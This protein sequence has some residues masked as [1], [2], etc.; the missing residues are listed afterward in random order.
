MGPSCGAQ[1]LTLPWQHP[2]QSLLTH[3]WPPWNLQG[4]F[5]EWAPLCPRPSPQK[6][7]RTPNLH[8]PLL[9]SQCGQLATSRQAGD[10]ALL[11]P[12]PASQSHVRFNISWRKG[13]G[14]R[15]SLTAGL[16]G[17]A[18]SQAAC[19]LV[20]MG[21]L[22]EGGRMR[23][24]I[25]ATRPALGTVRPRPALLSTWRYRA[26]RHQ[27]AALA[28]K[29]NQ[30]PAKSLTTAADACRWGRVGVGVGPQTHQAPYTLSTFPPT[31]EPA[32][33][34]PGVPPGEP[35]HLGSELLW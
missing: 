33:R 25:S 22:Q 8:G 9:T 31:M 29:E 30:C 19:A 1:G 2:P 21:P 23:R 15:C 7:Y 24:R 17:M 12:P 5:L 6:V 14:L 26:Y 4:A 11:P 13:V 18:R 27:S 10:T 3:P 20:H 16:T 34:W 28:R 32:G 35:I